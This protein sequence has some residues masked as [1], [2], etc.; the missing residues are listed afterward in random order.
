LLL[1]G[2]EGE[3]GGGF[4]PEGNAGG[5]DSNITALVNALIG[6]NLKINHTERESNHI[7]LTEFRK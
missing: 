4:N 3:F 7:K 2:F 6:A 1:L 5:L